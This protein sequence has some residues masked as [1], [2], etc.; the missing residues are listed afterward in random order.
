MELLLWLEEIA[1]WRLERKE[2]EMSW[3]SRPKDERPSE[4][5]YVL[6]GLNEIHRRAVDFINAQDYTASDIIV[7]ERVRYE[8]EHGIDAKF[9]YDLNCF[10]RR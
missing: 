4:E 3:F 5:D 1:I 7:Q 2:K 9:D 10:K 6:N 8:K